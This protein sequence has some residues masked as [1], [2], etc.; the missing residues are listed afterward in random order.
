MILVQ[1]TLNILSHTYIHTNRIEVPAGGFINVGTSASPAQNVTFYLNHSN[2]DHLVT[3]R[4]TWATDPAASSCLKNGE[5]EVYGSFIVHGV[6]RTS[7]TELTA[8]CHSTVHPCPS[9]LTTSAM[10]DLTVNNNCGCSTIQVE[11]CEGWEVNDRIVISYNMG[12]FPAENALQLSPTRTISSIT[13]NGRACSIA[14]NESTPLP[15]IGKNNPFLSATHKNGYTVSV[16]AEVANFERSVLFTGPLHWRYEEGQQPGVPGTGDPLYVPD[17][18]LY[19][20]Q[21]I[22]TVAYEQ[23]VFEINYARFENC[24]RVLLGAYCIHS[25]WKDSHG[26]KINGIATNKTISKVVT[27]HGT[28]NSVI[29]NSVM[30]NHR[31]ATVYYENGAEFN[32]LLQGNFMACEQPS[33]LYTGKCGLLDGVPSQVNA[34]YQEQAVIYSLSAGAADIVGNRICGND[35]AHFFEQSG[36]EWGQDRAMNK[37]A[38]KATQGARFDYNVIHNVFGFSWYAN[39]HA[40]MK[41]TLDADGYITDWHQAC[42]YDTRTSEDNSGTYSAHHN[43]EYHSDFGFGGYTALQM[44]VKNYTSIESLKA[45]YLKTIWRSN[46]TAPFVEDAY[47]KQSDSNQGPE[48]PGGHALVELSNVVFDHSKMKLSHHCR[49]AGQQTGGMCSSCYW[50]HDSWGPYNTT[51]LLEDETV[52]HQSSAIV[53]WDDIGYTLFLVEGHPTFDVTNECTTRPEKRG[54]TWQLCPQSWKVRPVVIY[55]PNRGTITVRD[56]TPGHQATSVN[57]PYT[58]ITLPDGG[59]IQNYCPKGKQEG[60]GYHFLV[61]DGADITITIAGNAVNQLSRDLFAVDYSQATWPT[62]KK[63]Q[64]TMTVDGSGAVGDGL[65]GGPFTISSDHSRAW[66]GPFGAF[67]SAAGAW[68]HAMSQHGNTSAWESVPSFYTLAAYE[69]QRAS[70]VRARTNWRSA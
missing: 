64:F 53:E 66:L 20:G 13:R 67:I 38:A 17:R 31:G 2:C 25:H 22:T 37:V 54:S 57:V 41:L 30:F 28:Q 6:P 33:H 60:N 39:R 5:L 35:N 12:R 7:W 9:A 8:D 11:E 27:I 19:G 23:A 45:I 49:I 55:S 62:H 40:P 52:N 46:G 56:N 16:G 43:V 24:G 61:R 32:N 65:S 18:E 50:I 47:F 36:T 26:I 70:D 29:E 59:H 4:E 3:N 21:G 34:D 69:T 51:L 44:S 63:S 1:G 58:P 14:L 48:L 15:H 10:S 42:M 68:W